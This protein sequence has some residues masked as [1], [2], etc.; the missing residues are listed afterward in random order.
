MTGVEKDESGGLRPDGS[1]KLFGAVRTNRRRHPC[2]C[3]AAPQRIVRR[4][5]LEIAGVAEDVGE[6][7]GQILYRHDTAKTGAIL[8]DKSVVAAVADLDRVRKALVHRRDIGE[9]TARCHDGKRSAG[10]PAKE[11]Q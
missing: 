11:E 1:A 2:A 10:L 8:H 9:T 5:D 6:R 7:G 4:G 3:G